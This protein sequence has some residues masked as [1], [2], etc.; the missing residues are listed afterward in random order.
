MTQQIENIKTLINNNNL[1]DAIEQLDA[2][3]EQD[4]TNDELFL[5]R[6]NAYRKMNNWKNAMSDYCKAI[7]IN[8]KSDAVQAYQAAQDIM[9]FF[10]KDLYNP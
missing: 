5:L 3:I 6:G 9:N 10:N 7:D 4:K 8:P 1:S 2:L